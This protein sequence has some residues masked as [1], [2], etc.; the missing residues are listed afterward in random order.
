MVKVV[1]ILGSGIRVNKKDEEPNFWERKFK[2]IKTTAIFAQNR[3]I[4]A[5]LFL[6]SPET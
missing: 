6:F 3:K 2:K 4:K 1:G 5:F